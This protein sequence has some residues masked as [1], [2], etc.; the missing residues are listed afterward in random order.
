MDLDAFRANSE[1]EVNGVW[2]EIEFRGQKG[3]FLI[4]RSGN[5]AFTRLYTKLKNQRVFANPDSQEAIDHD[6]DCLNRAFAE[7]ILLDTGDEITNNGEPVKYTP[8]LGYQLMTDPELT[9]LKNQLAMKA[10]DFEN[11]AVKRLDEIAKN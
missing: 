1:K 3:K 4:A 8:E 6:T 7:A 9:E 5:P 11:Y 10:G 2:T